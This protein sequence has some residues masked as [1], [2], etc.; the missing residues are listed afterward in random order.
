MALSPRCCLSCARE[1]PMKDCSSEDVRRHLNGHCRS[2]ERT[3]KT[4]KPDIQAFPSGQGK[5]VV[6]KSTLV[7]AREDRWRF[8][9]EN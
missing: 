2:F 3:S 4:P 9:C 7:S 5:C 8:Q 1:D 6:L